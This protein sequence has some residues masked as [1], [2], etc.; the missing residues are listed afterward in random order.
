[1]RAYSQATTN[2]D[3][4]GKSSATDYVEDGATQYIICK[5]V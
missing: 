4:T 2:E 5:T 1:M 3:I